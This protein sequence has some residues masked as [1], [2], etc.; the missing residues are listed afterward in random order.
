MVHDL[1]KDVFGLM[2]KPS[3][4]TLSGVNFPLPAFFTYH[5]L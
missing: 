3:V 4:M 5:T 1:V 2:Q